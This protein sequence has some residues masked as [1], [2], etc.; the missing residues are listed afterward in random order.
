M[1]EKA[2]ELQPERPARL[3]VL[4]GFY[5]RQGDFDKTIEA[6]QKRA[7][8]EPN[9]PEAWHTIGDFYY[10]KVLRDTDFRRTPFRKYVLIGHLA[11]RTRPWS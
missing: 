7:D 8:P 5:N 2:I 3:P 10:D 9:N 6:F 1:F 4:A 11:P